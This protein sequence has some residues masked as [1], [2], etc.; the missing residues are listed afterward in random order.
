LLIRDLSIK[1]QAFTLQSYLQGIEE[2]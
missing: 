2:E 1:G